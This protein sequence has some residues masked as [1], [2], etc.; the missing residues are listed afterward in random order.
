MKTA[1]EIFQ[2]IDKKVVGHSEA[3]KILSV[4]VRNHCLRC[5]RPDLGIKKANILMLGPSGVGKTSLAIALS[6]AVNLPIAIADATSL[7]QAGYVG[8]DVENVLLRLIQAANGDVRRAEHGIVFIDEFDKV[9][10]KSESASITR[11][12]SGEGVQQA[13]LKLVEG[14]LVNVPASGGRKRPDGVGYIPINTKDILFICSGAFSDISNRKEIFTYDLV[15]AGVI[16]EMVRRLPVIAKLNALTEQ[17]VY[18]VLTSCENSILDQYVKLFHEL[19]C[20]LRIGEVACRQISRRAIE[21]D[22]GASGLVR[23]MEGLLLDVMFNLP[24]ESIKE[25]KIESL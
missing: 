23:I 5:R 19:D 16:P 2:I 24:D 4:A 15:H 10:R 20:D 6:E 1:K 22:I 25:Y 12:V 17:E 21:Q 3:K 11:D 18:E 9:A 14:S 7:T 8:E 13:L